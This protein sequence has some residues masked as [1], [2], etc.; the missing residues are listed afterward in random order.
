[1]YLY[2]GWML[3]HLDLLEH[4]T[5]QFFQY[6][7]RQV[8]RLGLLRLRITRFRLMG[9]RTRSGRFTN[10][11]MRFIENGVRETNEDLYDASS[12]PFGGI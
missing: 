7:L 11:R 10:Y 2:L 12:V 4:Y 3:H 1:M 9:T 6:S 8:T 5:F